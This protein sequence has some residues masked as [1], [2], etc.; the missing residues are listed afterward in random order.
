MQRFILSTFEMGLPQVSPN[1]ADEVTATL[2]ISASTPP[3]FGGVSGLDLD[4]L[5]GK[6]TDDPFK[7]RNDIRGATSF[8]GLKI[9]SQGT[10]GR[11]HPISGQ[12]V[13]RPAMQVLGFESGHLGTA[14]SG[15]DEEVSDELR[16]S[17]SANSSASSIDPHGP[18]KRLLSPLN[19][20][21]QKQ[22]HGDF[23]D[24]GCSDARAGSL[25]LVRKDSKLKSHNHKKAN[26]GTPGS[27][28]SLV[29]PS[30]RFSNLN[31]LDNRLTC[32]LFSDCPLLEQNEP[33][34]KKEHM[35]AL[36]FS[37]LGPKWLERLK[38][39]GSQR[40]IMDDIQ[41]DLLALK[42]L[43]GP[44][45]RSGTDM[46]LFTDEDHIRTKDILEQNNKF[47]DESG[48]LKP[49]GTLYR[50]RNWDTDSINHAKRLSVLPVRRSLVGSFEESLLSGRLSSGKD[51]QRIDG[52]LAVLNVTGGKF[53]PPSQRI[54]FSVSTVDGDS[55]LLY[56]ASIDLTGSVPK[57]KKKG[58]KLRRSLSNK[59]SH[60]AKSLLCI[61]MKGRIQLVLSNP[62]MTPLHTFF[63][64]YDLSDMPPGTKTFMR[65]KVTLASSGSLL[66]QLK[67][68]NK[69]HD[70]NVG[71][72]SSALSNGREHIDHDRGSTEC[73]IHRD[74]PNES[75]SEVQKNIYFSSEDSLGQPD[76][77]NCCMN[78]KY[79]SE[80][81]R[82]QSQRTFDTSHFDRC[83]LS[84]RAS[85]H[86]S[87]SNNNAAC[88]GVLR[89]ALHLR[90]LSPS[91][92]K[93]SKS[94]QRC[95]S[96]MSSGPCSNNMETEGKQRYYLYDDLRV[97]FPQ[98]HS[99]ADE[100]KLKVEHHFP[101]N[102]K[103]FDISN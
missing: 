84:D 94:M 53:S 8:L 1:I 22:F 14:F 12:T 43:K 16:S 35:Q 10:N 37:P 81:N 44:N 76:P 73:C 83:H 100:G 70:M 4:V 95:L 69:D 30:S 67:E 52:F 25:D 41:S 65:Q 36:S 15:F 86:C 63:C 68:E 45:G 88:G 11:F 2:S 75:Q 92:R 34:P 5:H 78:G 48:Q 64:N 55:S 18:R 9:D 90:F 6:G 79:S 87:L 96:D 7:Y 50:G 98:R 58:R 24:I 40:D 57:S 23:L 103:F 85:S 97:V 101:A 99:D 72:K 42:D 47:H 31:N 17:S 56:Y 46:L 26:I 60:M 89:Y 62:E 61:P 49:K 19:S 27:F 38:N 29:W 39:A 91:S 33:S 3:H 74:L 20:T 66:N 32:N 102:P 77:C 93:S 82:N 51:S 59:D 28:S 71:R 80:F 54:P 21:L 13:H